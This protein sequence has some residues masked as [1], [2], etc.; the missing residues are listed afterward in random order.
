MKK[1]ISVLL[2][3]AVAVGTASCSDVKGG[4][5]GAV[6]Y[7][8]DGQI[9]YKNGDTELQLTTSLPELPA[10]S[11]IYNYT[12]SPLEFC[13]INTA[14]NRVFYPEYVTALSPRLI[15]SPISVDLYYQD[16]GKDGATAVAK[17]VHS[18]FVSSDGNTVTYQDSRG[19]YSLDL[20]TD[21][22]T[23]IL[24]S[25]PDS[26]HPTSDGQTV[27]YITNGS[28]IS[29]NYYE[30]K[31]V[32][33][34]DALDILLCDDDYVFYT[35]GD[36]ESDRLC[37]YD[38]DGIFDIIDSPYALKGAAGRYYVM[39][40]SENERANSG[41]V[42]EITVGGE[43]KMVGESANYNF[44]EVDSDGKVYYVE[45]ENIFSDDPILYCNDTVVS[46]E[47]PVYRLV[48]SDGYK[49]IY[50]VSND[51]LMTCRDGKLETVYEW[52]ASGE[53]AYESIEYYISADGTVY[54][55]LQCDGTLKYCLLTD[56][57]LSELATATSTYINI[58]QSGALKRC[59]EILPE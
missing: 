58:P 23:E 7:V 36:D 31:T 49:G 13:H 30:T 2:I 39:T 1:I 33:E 37:A 50:V 53:Y 29:Y 6:V 55:S 35:S 26:Y 59:P 3:L 57:K 46:E 51:N 43:P 34:K 25:I 52:T 45:L 11:A 20:K 24:G 44:F 12:N 40:R 5:H 17:D 28:L 15:M 4:S 42:Y 56:G 41:S 21:E 32:T 47:T 54:A 10:D 27:Y 18:Y 38:G 16:I 22:K 14:A 19:L 9:A 48:S 8:E